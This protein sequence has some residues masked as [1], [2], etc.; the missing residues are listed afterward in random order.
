MMRQPDPPRKT[1]DS[2]VDSVEAVDAIN[3]QLEVLV[4]GENPQRMLEL[5]RRANA[6]ARRLTYRKGQAYSRLFMGYS[7]KTLIHRHA[8]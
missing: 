4:S 1:R 3:A 7:T 5:S 2:F 8:M 6:M